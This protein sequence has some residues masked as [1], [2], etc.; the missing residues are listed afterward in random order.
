MGFNDFS[1]SSSSGSGNVALLVADG[2][3]DD[4][5]KIWISVTKALLIPSDKNPN[6][7]PVDIFESDVGDEIELL[8]LRDQDSLLTVKKRVPAGWYSKIR[9][10]VKDIWCEGDPCDNFKLPSNKIDLNPR[11]DFEVRSG[12]TLAI[13]LDIDADKSKHKDFI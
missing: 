7:L 5:S 1:S 10:E 2:P 13:R 4:Y 8:D 12:E 6:R 3:A 9:L 11:S